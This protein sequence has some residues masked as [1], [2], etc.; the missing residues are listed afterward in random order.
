[1]K[2]QLCLAVAALLLTA[3]A[4]PA[5]EPV[6]P[7]TAEDASPP[8]A[9]ETPA[10]PTQSPG[11]PQPAEQAVPL[12][13][14]DAQNDAGRYEAEWDYNTDTV[15][16]RYLD[17]NAAT[18]QIVGEPLELPNLNADLFADD[19]YLYW[20]WSGMVNDTPVLLRSE[21]DGSDRAPLYE[22][23]QGTS[24]AVW[25]WDSGFASDGG[26]LYFRYCQIS[27]DP[28]VPDV[29]S[30][31]R[32]A[33]EAQ[34]LETL[35]TWSPF[36]GELVGVWND[37]LLITRRTLA[38]DCPVAPV[39]GH[40]HVDNLNDLS[41]WMTTSLCALDPATGEEEVLYECSGS[42]LDRRLEDGALWRVNE[43]H[44]ILYRPLGENEDTMLTQL[45]Q[46]MQFLNVYTTDVTFNSYEGERDWLYLYDRTTG[47]L[48]RSPRRRWLG[49]EDRAIWVVCE[50]GPG[51]YVVIDD[52]SAGMQAMADADGNQYLID[53]YARYAIASRDAL[54]DGSIPLTPVT[55]PGTV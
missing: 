38:E 27:D 50:A 8:Q 5:S 11:T 47:S 6:A 40:Y 10:A 31:V 13:W 28:A 14:V 26:S 52:A 42:W 46:G 22:F 30:L 4:A 20:F 45:P 37:R 3:C 34:T 21:L 39:Y 23:P 55:R 29:Y 36:G 24:L 35:T 41:D 15:V 25:N 53:G 43:Q 12:Y 7:A 19:E 32:L 9:V 44:E 18:E 2:K 17:F 54:L 49:G 33:P 1:M 51:Q 16:A 48:T